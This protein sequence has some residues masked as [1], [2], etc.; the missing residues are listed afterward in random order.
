MYSLILYWYS[1]PTGLLLWMCCQQL[2]IQPTKENKKNLTNNNKS[3][4][5]TLSVCKV[6]TPIRFSGAAQILQLST[7][8]TE[9]ADAIRGH[10]PLVCDVIVPIGRERKQARYESCMRLHC[11]AFE[12]PRHTQFRRV[13]ENVPSRPVILIK[14]G[15]KGGNHIPSISLV[16]R[17]LLRL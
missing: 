12:G 17:S 10:R 9:P 13:S 3:A 11:L 8:S 6:N 15:E 1:T 5:K 16:K 14:R 7:W 2:K 4:R